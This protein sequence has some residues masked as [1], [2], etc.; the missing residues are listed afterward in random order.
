MTTV[1]KP[2]ISV[3]TWDT[4]PTYSIIGDFRAAE[5]AAGI[6][7]HDGCY[8]LGRILNPI[9]EAVGGTY[10]HEF[11]CNY[12]YFP[13]AEAAREFA[14]RADVHLMRLLNASKLPADDL[15][16]PWEG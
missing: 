9:A 13:S 2:K 15:L 14:R 3:S 5:K 11:S 1:F 10:D 6:D 12:W 7:P 4:A 8:G 16:V